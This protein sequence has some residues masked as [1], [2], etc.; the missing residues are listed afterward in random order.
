MAA[1]DGSSPRPWGTRQGSILHSSGIRFIPTPVGN[2]QPYH[3]GQH[4]HSVQDR[5]R[6]EQ[7]KSVDLGGRRIIKKPRPW[8]TRTAKLRDTPGRRFIPTPVGNTLNA[9]NILQTATVHPHA[10]GEHY[11]LGIAQSTGHGSS[12]RPWGTHCPEKDAWLLHRFI[13]TPVG[14]T[15]TP[16]N[17]SRRAPVHPHARGE[18]YAS[19]EQ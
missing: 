19:R 10:R 5:K 3:D 17:I 8:G 14:N 16:C 6:V 11:G 18:H 12:P 9:I 7:G 1:P 15:L 4:P 13:P 2:T